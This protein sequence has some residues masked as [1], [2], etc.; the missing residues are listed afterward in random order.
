MAAGVGPSTGATAL[1]SGTELPWAATVP[2]ASPLGGLCDS[3]DLQP[4]TSPPPPQPTAR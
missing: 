4:T 3:V 2:V 1:P